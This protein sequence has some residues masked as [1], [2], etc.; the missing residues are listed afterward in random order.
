MKLRRGKRKD[1][2]KKII[3]WEKRRARRKFQDNC[4]RKGGKHEISNCQS[5]RSVSLRQTYG[6]LGARGRV[7]SQNT[8]DK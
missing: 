3:N 6:S 5:Q 4:R 2:G 1:E 8:K 7:L